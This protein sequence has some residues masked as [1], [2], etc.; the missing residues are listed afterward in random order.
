MWSVVKMGKFLGADVAESERIFENEVKAREYA[1][2][3]IKQSGVYG[4]MLD[5]YDN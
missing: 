1:A 5:Y 2:F 3:I 4:V